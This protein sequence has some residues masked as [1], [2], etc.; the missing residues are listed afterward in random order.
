VSKQH[1]SLRL[2]APEE[3]LDVSLA[4]STQQVPVGLQLSPIAD[5]FDA[6][7]RL[8]GKILA[9]AQSNDAELLGLMIIGVI[10][11][12]EFYFRSILGRAIQI[13]PV[14][15]RQAESAQVPI[16]AFSF[17]EDSDYCFVLG[18]MEHESLA[19]AKRVAAYINKLTGF[20]TDDDSS[21]VAALQG[22]EA[23]CELR[24]CLAHAR[25]F[26]GLK[27]SRALGLEQRKV[28][29]VLVN[30]AGAFELLKLSH[31]AVRAVNRFLLDSLVNR[32]IDRDIL[33]GTWADDRNVFG[34][35]WRSFSMTGEDGFNGNVRSA[36]AVVRQSIVKRQQAIAAKA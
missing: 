17:Y 26:V 23:L 3:Q 35:A 9:A 10:S 29:K 4:E 18:A 27:G 13:C 15:A 19:D 1:V 28:S 32:W 33:S 20:K 14:C 36:Y 7:S 11:A 12:A 24:H 34:M 8:K 5:Y 21:V 16:G 30:Q 2:H 6:T 25:G 31:N 22:Y